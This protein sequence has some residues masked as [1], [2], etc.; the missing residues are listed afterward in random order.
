M[1]TPQLIYSTF[2]IKPYLMQITKNV[3]LLLSD[4]LESLQI[5]R[6]DNYTAIWELVYTH[7][8]THTL[9]ISSDFPGSLNVLAALSKLIPLIKKFEVQLKYRD[10]N[11]K[12]ILQPL[13]I[14][15]S[16]AAVV[17]RKKSCIANGAWFGWSRKTSI[18]MKTLKNLNPN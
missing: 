10:I 5:C 14:L 8:H 12:K 11:L 9:I 13:A 7:T 16:T 15:A 6:L 1:L 2:R 3:V 18:K 4:C 17:N